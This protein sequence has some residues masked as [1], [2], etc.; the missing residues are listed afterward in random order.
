MDVFEDD[1]NKVTI[2]VQCKQRVKSQSTFITVTTRNHL[3]ESQPPNHVN[4]LSWL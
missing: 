1:E 4:T 3:D 2:V